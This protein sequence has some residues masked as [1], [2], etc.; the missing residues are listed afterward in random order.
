[1]KNNKA[2][3]GAKNSSF[4]KMIIAESKPLVKPTSKT[5]L[6][7]IAFL[8]AGRRGLHTFDVHIQSEIHAKLLE[9]SGKYWTNC[10]SSD[11]SKL[12]RR[13]GIDIHDQFEPYLSQHGHTTRFKRYWI[14][15]RAQALLALEVIN[16]LRV[17]RG[18]EKLTEAERAALL[19]EYPL[20]N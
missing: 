16:H 20:S 1:M 15:D 4:D 8:I 12:K 3:E 7:L 18:A 14:P 11:V 9:G 17:I 5:E 2:P 10:L 6:C 13:H 19:V